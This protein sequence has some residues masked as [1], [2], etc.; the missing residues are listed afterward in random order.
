MCPNPTVR[1][2]KKKKSRFYAVC[3]GRQV[4]VYT[5]Y[6]EYQDQVLGYKGCEGRTFNSRAQAE[7]WLREELPHHQAEKG[8]EK[9]LAAL[10]IH[11][12]GVE[13]EDLEDFEERVDRVERAL[14]AAE[15]EN[16]P[17]Q[18]ERS[19]NSTNSTN[20]R[21]R[22]SVGAHRFLKHSAIRQKEPVEIIRRNLPPQK[23]TN[24]CVTSKA[25]YR[26][27][28]TGV[29]S[30][31]VMAVCRGIDQDMQ[32][33][34]PLAFWQRL[35]S[36]LIDLAVETLPSPEEDRRIELAKAGLVAEMERWNPPMDRRNGFSRQL[37][38]AT[39]NFTLKAFGSYASRLHSRG[40]DID[41]QVD[42][43]FYECGR[44]D[45][46]R[47]VMQM[48]RADAQKLIHVFGGRLTNCRGRYR[49]EKIPRARM[50][51]L[52]VRDLHLD[53]SCDIAFP[54][55]N[56]VD[57]PKSELLLVLNHLDS[58]LH[59]L[60]ALVKMWAAAA[61]LR[62]A[63]IGRF[64]T[65]TL[66]SLIIFY[67]QTVKIPV[68]PPLREIIPPSLV[69]AAKQYQD[70]SNHLADMSERARKWCLQQNQRQNVN[71]DGV[72]ELFLGFLC[73]MGDTFDGIFGLGGEG[74]H[75]PLKII[76]YTAS[77]CRWRGADRKEKHRNQ[78]LFVADPFDLEDNSARALQLNCLSHASRCAHNAYRACGELEIDEWMN[79]MFHDGPQEGP[80]KKVRSR[81]HKNGRGPGGG[82]RGP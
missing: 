79:F 26:G 8:L 13:L 16:K 3:R 36:E 67:L 28:V 31:G 50:P 52:K 42:G 78:L 61:Q 48:R 60:L 51:I 32:H 49:V 56:A 62:D 81:R 43:T 19:A 17:R 63:S 64:N 33:Q 9:R 6:A 53:V 71:T 57:W 24:W 20:S 25:W 44:R 37:A 45:R 21:T 47:H 46:A 38:D 4:G 23:P 27:V 1:P 40:S 14:S 5:D 18:Q 39:W 12:H 10:N 35:E 15:N 74:Q 58:R 65:Y 2:K 30:S 59:P 66:T 75:C 73:W 55:E 29:G 69:E 77:C 54:N 11:G 7:T 22:Q 82:P 68:L 76:T 41:L 34:F 70:L 72:M 80:K